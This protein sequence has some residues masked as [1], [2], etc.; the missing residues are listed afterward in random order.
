MQRRTD[1]VEIEDDVTTVMRCYFCKGEL[2]P[3]RTA[4][5]FEAGEHVIT[6]KNIPCDKCV[7]CGEPVLTGEVVDH[8]HKL[9]DEFGEDL[10]RDITVD[11]Q[12]LVREA[13]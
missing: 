3:G 11:Y 8:V 9:V 2:R 10:N 5:T 12:K 4:I 1:P 7:Q 6:V 13:A